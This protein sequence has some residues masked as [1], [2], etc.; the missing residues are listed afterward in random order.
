MLVTLAGSPWFL[1]ELSWKEVAA[2]L[3]AAIYAICKR[4]TD[5]KIERHNG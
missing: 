1:G 3:F 4:D 5:K 2:A